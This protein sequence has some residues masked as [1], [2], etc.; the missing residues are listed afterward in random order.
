MFTNFEFKIAARYLRSRKKERFI[1]VIAGFSFLG[2]A[3][4]VATLIIVMAVMNGFRA[5]LYDKLVGMRGHIACIPFGDVS[6]AKTRESS[7]KIKLLDNVR[8][9]TI[10]LER[11]AILSYNNHSQG[12]IILGIDPTDFQQLEVIQNDKLKGDLKEFKQNSVAISYNLAQ[13]LNLSAGENIQVLLPNGIKTPFGSSTKQKSFNTPILFKIGMHQFDKN[14][15][16]MPLKTA[17]EFFNMPNQ[18]SRIDVHVKNQQL[19]HSTRNK[20]QNI[21]GGR[22]QVVD[23]KHEDANVFQAVQVEKNVMF[24]IL[25]LIIIIAAFNVISGMLMLVKD[26]HKD[27][28]ILRTMGV[29]KNNMLKIFFLTGSAIG[30]GGTMLGSA[31]GISVAVNIEKIR[32]FIERFLDNDLF[33]E[34]IYFLSKLP[35]K[36]IWPEVIGVCGIAVI[37]TLLA[38]LYP[39]WYASRLDPIATLRL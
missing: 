8:S 23:W 12:I 22:Y 3:L 14:Y 9:S 1:S 13:S 11:Q 33:Q 2:I 5:E 16:F 21:L 28:A 29:Q 19:L 7:E 32:K 31:I 36:I 4:G 39:A 30:I 35:S 10:Y 6:M 15:A 18:I 24:I 34:E 17:Q 26:K 25:T 20:I 27:I 38:T 37:L